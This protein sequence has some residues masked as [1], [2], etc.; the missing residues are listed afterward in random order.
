MTR[1]EAIERAGLKYVEQ[2]EKDNC[3][4]TNRVTEGTEWQGYTEF[5]AASD[6]NE[7]KERVV[8]YYYQSNEVLE[9]MREAYD[10]DLGGLDWEIDH[11]EVV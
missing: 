11:Y 4:F 9:K 3:D 8:V 1:A 10:T 2:A 5:S 7:N 6:L